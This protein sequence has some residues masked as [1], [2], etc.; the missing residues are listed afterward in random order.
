MSDY[1]RAILP[2]WDSRTKQVERVM[3][4]LI[5]ASGME[6]VDWEALQRSNVLNDIAP[7]G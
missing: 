6:G 2:Q 4:R 7:A 1:G 5:P 3:R